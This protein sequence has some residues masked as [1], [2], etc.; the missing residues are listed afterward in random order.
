M[1]A[2]A[3]ALDQKGDS[4]GLFCP[5]KAIYVLHSGNQ[6]CSLALVRLPNLAEPN[7]LI[8]ITLQLGCGKDVI[9]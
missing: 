1:S 7:F 9:Q 8:I 5:V 6:F 3:R 2:S 4:D